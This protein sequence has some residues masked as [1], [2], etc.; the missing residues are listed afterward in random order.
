M[1]T[2]S[3]LLQRDRWFLTDLALRPDLHSDSEFWLSSPVVMFLSFDLSSMG[4]KQGPSNHKHQAAVC[5]VQAPLDLMSFD[6]MNG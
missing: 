6:S 5:D 2:V 1:L 4:I 3:L